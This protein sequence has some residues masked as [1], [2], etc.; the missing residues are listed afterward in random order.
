MPH[1]FDFDKLNK[2]STVDVY[3]EGWVH[4]VTVEYGM[5]LDGDTPAYFWRLKGT[6]HTF[7]IPAMRLNF[8]SSGNYAEHFTEALRGFREDYLQ[9]KKYGFPAEWMQQ[10]RD[11]Y[12]RHIHE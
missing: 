12:S 11:E 2:V 6:R 9:W 1:I 8:L 7:V 10:Y 4:P 5:A 3:P